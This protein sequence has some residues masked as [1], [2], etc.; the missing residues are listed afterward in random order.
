MTL[1]PAS[2]A[3]PRLTSSD[4]LV[5]AYVLD[6]EGRGQPISWGGLSDWRPEHGT[7]WVHL[8]RLQER[9]ARWLMRESGLAPVVAEAVMAEETRPRVDSFDSGLLLVLRGANL[10][11]GAAPEDMV[12]LRIWADE[13]RVVTVRGRRV[14][15]VEDVREA[16]ARG[17]GPSNSGQ[18]LTA[19]L[20]QL[21][22]RLE[23]VVSELDD[24]VDELEERATEAADSS[25][26]RELS[27]A[28]RR[29]IALRRHM[30]PQRAV[31]LRLQSEPVD[32]I[33]DL[34]RLHVREAHDQLTRY[35]EDLD[36]A[37]DRATVTHEEITQRVAED[38]NRTIYLLSVV[39]TIFLPLSL[40][41]GLLGMNVGGIPGGS[42]SWGFAAV[43]GLTLALAVLEILLI[44]RLRVL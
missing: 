33:A 8:D 15:S 34:D 12:S 35:L 22:D 18:L 17:H 1:D 32:W 28:R 4:G 7:L 6:G 19:L 11:P 9:A 36:E 26:R 37:R 41:A 13:H 21:T 20:S 30:A 39:A 27:V 23:P 3:P 44:R 42:E 29:V 2:A 38:T 14:M 5:A 16:L 40:L 24:V 10:N 25:L 43:I 31:T